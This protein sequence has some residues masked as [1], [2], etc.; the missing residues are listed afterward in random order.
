MRRI[1]VRL[2]EWRSAEHRRGALSPGSPAWQ[3]ADDEVR[4]AQAAYRG[5]AS[6][7]AAYYAEL[8]FAAHD[9][10]YARWPAR[11]DRPAALNR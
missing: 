3:A 7:A 9:R 2:E 6:Q 5:E 8:E 11:I 10:S 4:Q 1:A